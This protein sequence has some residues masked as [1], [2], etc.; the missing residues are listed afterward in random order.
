MSSRNGHAHTYLYD[1]VQLAFNTHLAPIKWVGANG[2]CCT[3]TVPSHI[4]R[5]VLIEIDLFATSSRELAELPKDRDSLI[6]SKE[7]RTMKIETYEW[8]VMV[9]NANT[10][11][12]DMLK[13][14]TGKGLYLY[15]IAEPG[16]ASYRL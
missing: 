16:L 3:S 8:S 15:S 10:R 2:V 9:C 14:K 11:Y 7:L 5:E 1:A 4:T 6:G 13:F 12:A